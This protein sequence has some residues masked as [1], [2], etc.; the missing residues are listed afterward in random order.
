M[1]YPCLIENAGGGACGM[2]AF[3]AVFPSFEPGFVYTTPPLG[4]FELSLGIYDPATVANASLT[5][6]PLPRLEAEAAFAVPKAL[7]SLRQRLLANDS[8][9][10][11]QR[12]A[13]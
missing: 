9:V 10:R 12:T 3:G 11:R 5:R 7:Q 6:A 2:A 8:K 4:G 1:G 13:C